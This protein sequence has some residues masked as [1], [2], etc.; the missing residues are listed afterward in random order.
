MK[1]QL[2]S[3]FYA[4][5]GIGDANTNLKETFSNV[6]ECLDKTRTHIDDIS[7]LSQKLVNSRR[8]I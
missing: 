6:M 8:C 4:I 5:R 7:K 1:K 2:L 3:F